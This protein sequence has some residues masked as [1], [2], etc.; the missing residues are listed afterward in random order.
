MKINELGVPHL[1][2]L[3]VADWSRTGQCDYSDMRAVIRTHRPALQFDLLPVLRPQLNEATYKD[4]MARIDPTFLQQ[5]LRTQDT[6]VLPQDGK[7][8]HGPKLLRGISY[9]GFRTDTMVF[10]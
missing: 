5:G 2:G 9:Q 8:Y 1:H 6:Y 3:W 10:V 7:T 4:L